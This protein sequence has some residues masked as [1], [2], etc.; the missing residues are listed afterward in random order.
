M[1]R[2][3]K[4]EYLIN[5][6]TMVILPH[7]NEHGHL[8]SLVMEWGRELLVSEK[9][10]E[11]IKNNC[12]FHGSSYQGRVEGAAHLTKYNRMVPIMI[13]NRSSIYFFPTHSPKTESCIWIAHGH[14]KE[15]VPSDADSCQVI[16]SNHR[17]IPIKVSRAAMEIKV[18]RTAQ[19]RHLMSVQDMQSDRSNRTEQFSQL[20][21]SVIMESTGA[22]SFSQNTSHF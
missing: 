17:A 22:Y 4:A 8:F 18:N 19:F 14:V 7:Y 9:P 15:I 20:E 2:L 10:M 5:G 16:L 6:E 13:C 11:I 1:A 12:L 21:Q 3:K